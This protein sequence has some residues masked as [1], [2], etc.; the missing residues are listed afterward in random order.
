MPPPGTVSPP[1]DGGVSRRRHCFPASGATSVYRAPPPA[2]T[3]VRLDAR[4]GSRQARSLRLSS[5]GD[6]PRPGFLHSPGAGR[7]S[8]AGGVPHLRRARRPPASR[9]ITQRSWCSLSCTGRTGG[10]LEGG[11]TMTVR[12]VCITAASVL[13]L[14]APATAFAR[15]VAVR[16]DEPPGSSSARAPRPGGRLTSSTSRRSAPCRSGRRATSTSRC[17]RTRAGQP[18]STA[19]CA[20]D[21]SACTDPVDLCQ[22]LG[23]VLTRVITWR[24][25]IPP[26]RRADVNLASQVGAVRNRAYRPGP[27]RAPFHVA[28]VL[29]GSAASR[30]GSGPPGAPL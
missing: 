20:T 11:D 19:D 14:A 3:G 25:P 10:R 21:M 28:L 18:S 4:V 5:A 15:E 1:D 16:S 26:T 22:Y 23:A 29:H 17:R 9:C 8:G 30:T 27:T 2:F 7:Y 13:A 6:R 24:A 12:T